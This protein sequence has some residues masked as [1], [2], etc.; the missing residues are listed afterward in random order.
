MPHYLTRKDNT[1]YFR[2]SVPQELR[3]IIGKREIKKSLGHD[4]VR[5]ISECKRYAVVADL[6]I[7]EA[8]IKLRTSALSVAKEA[9]EAANI[10]KSAFLANM[11]HESRTPMNGVL[12]MAHLIRRGGVTTKQA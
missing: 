5:A 11:S 8:P 4:Y 7:A 3:P 2:Q 9:A 10:A 6:L 1:F 12:G